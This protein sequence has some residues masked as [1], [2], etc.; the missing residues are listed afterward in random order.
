MRDLEAVKRQK[1]AYFG[2]KETVAMSGKGSHLG[3]ILSGWRR[4]GRLRLSWL[5]SVKAWTGLT[6]EKEHERRLIE[7][8]GEDCSWCSQ[9]SD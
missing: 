1:L 5:D 8:I 3:T 9:P 7:T 2:H 6:L 4:R